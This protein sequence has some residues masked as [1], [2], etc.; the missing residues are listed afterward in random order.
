LGFGYG[1]YHWSVALACGL[2]VTGALVA[3]KDMILK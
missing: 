1:Q 3:A 2:I